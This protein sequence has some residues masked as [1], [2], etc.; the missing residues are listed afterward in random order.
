MPNIG[1]Q[2][3]QSDHETGGDV[4]RWAL[5]KAA[6]WGGIAIGLA[7]IVGPYL[8]NAS[9]GTAEPAKPVADAARAVAKPPDPVPNSLLYRADSRGHI[10]LEAA[11]NGEPLR[12]MVDTGATFVTLSRAAA[13]AAGIGPA[14]LVFDLPVETANGRA[15][16]ARVSLREVRLQQLTLYDVPALVSDNLGKTSLLGMSFLSRLQGYEM[17]DG[18]LT[19]SW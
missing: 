14:E 7:L 1:R 11:V 5:G 3:H 4:V 6:L 9:R 15:R 12:F 19:L 13:A 8:G 10:F 18:V 17:R 2:H 16:A